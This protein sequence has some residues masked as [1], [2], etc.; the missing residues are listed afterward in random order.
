MVPSGGLGRETERKLTISSGGLAWKK[1]SQAEE[2]AAL[3][4]KQEEMEAAAEKLAAGDASF[5]RFR[6]FP[7]L[8]FARA[9]WQIALPPLVRPTTSPRSTSVVPSGGWKRGKWAAN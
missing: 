6:P 3:K 2:T 5:T 7:P 8:C 9:L 1:H 4:I